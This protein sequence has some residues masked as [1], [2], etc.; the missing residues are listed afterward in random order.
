MDFPARQQSDRCTKGSALRTAIFNGHDDIARLL[1]RAQYCIPTMTREYFQALAATTRLGRIE[2]MQL[3]IQTTKRDL[4]QDNCWLA[5]Q[6]L[7]LAVY[8]KQTAMAQWFID[9]GIDINARHSSPT[10]QVPCALS[11]ACGQGNLPLVYLLLENGAR[12]DYQH[13]DSGYFSYDP[14]QLAAK[15]G[16]L[17]IVQL[18]LK[19]GA[20]AKTALYE[21]AR[22]NQ[23]HI[24]DWLCQRD[25]SL[26]WMKI[27]EHN[28]NPIGYLALFSAVAKL[29]RPMIK[30][31]VNAGVTID[32]MYGY[33][34]EP[35]VSFAKKIYGPLRTELLLSMGA[36]D[37]YVPEEEVKKDDVEGYHG[38]ELFVSE[39][40]REWVGRSLEYGY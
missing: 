20:D 4:L 13:L 38:R 17:E 26:I 1:L 23:T 24:V 21:A 14:I 6:I 15:H 30:V 36:T 34:R 16:H 31:L 18:L 37:V 19:H 25:P 7:R 28:P 11:S 35:L 3:L 29:N 39:R 2:M 32:E 9:R 10:N 27:S 22:A 33:D 5:E 40:S 8:F 12:G